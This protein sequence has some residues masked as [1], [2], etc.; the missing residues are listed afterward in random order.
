MTMTTETATHRHTTRR[1]IPDLM[2]IAATLRILLETLGKIGDAIDPMVPP[3]NGH[4]PGTD[5]PGA[6]CAQDYLR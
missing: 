1:Y 5:L 2:D 6:E 3:M 4:L